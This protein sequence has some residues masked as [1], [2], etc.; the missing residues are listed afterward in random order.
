[1]VQ[2]RA[3]KDVPKSASELK[4]PGEVVG[5]EPIE[6]LTDKAAGCSAG[7]T[8]DYST[9]RV[10]ERIMRIGEPP[11]VVPRHRHPLLR[12]LGFQAEARIANILPADLVIH[13]VFVMTGG[14]ELIESAAVAVFWVVVAGRV[15]V[16][17]RNAR[18][19]MGCGQSLSNDPV[20]CPRPHCVGAKRACLPV[21]FC[22]IV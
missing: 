11:R 18:V 2:E 16:F 1:M 4:L 9:R 8:R 10:I 15:V 19:Q 3:R 7:N 21:Y 17:H 12:R 5:G 20:S 22:S 14:V 13:A 6:L